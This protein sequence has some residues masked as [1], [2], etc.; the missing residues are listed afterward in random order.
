MIY[1]ENGEL[2]IV[3]GGERTVSVYIGVS[4][5]NYNTCEHKFGKKLDHLRE[6]TD[7]P[8]HLIF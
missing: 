1:P 4:L 2:E 3:R 6:N 8:G 5:H 7:Y